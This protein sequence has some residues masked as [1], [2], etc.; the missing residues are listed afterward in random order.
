MSTTEYR[1]RVPK[2]GVFSQISKILSKKWHGET[3]EVVYVYEGNEALFFIK[4]VVQM[5]KR[6]RRQLEAMRRQHE[7]AAANPPNPTLASMPDGF[8]PQVGS[9]GE[10]ITRIDRSGVDQVS[11]VEKKTKA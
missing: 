3:T 4:E 6:Q 11:G 1:L 7:M 5:D 8:Y 2:K 9:L 10:L